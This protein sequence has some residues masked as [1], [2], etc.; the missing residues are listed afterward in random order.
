MQQYFGKITID[1][2]PEMPAG[3]EVRPLAKTMFV[4]YPDCQ[5]LIIWLPQYG[6]NYGAMRLIDTGSKQVIDERP[7]TDRL[8]GSIQLLWDTLD[9][10][11]GEYRVE[12]DHPEGW[13]H[14]IE[15]RKY[16][17]RA[18]LP[19]EPPAEPEPPKES[20][21]IVYRDGFGNIIPNTDLELRE[22]AMQDITNKFARRIE[23]TG[24][25]RAGE[26]I[27]VDNKRRIAFWHEMGG[28]NCMFYIDIPP[29]AQWE[30]RTGTPLEERAEI[31]EFVASTVRSQQASNCRY[32]IG[33]REIGFYYM[34][35]RE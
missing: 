15:L 18:V 29:A 19:A 2:T 25:F 22:K 16:H 33:E 32:E 9:I 7:V 8:S 14:C 10:P 1:E 3:V 13:K 4:H 12:I 11:P 35:S 27:Y 24:T 20:G 31:L 6:R 28:G 30:E 21:P 17:E 23:Y 5:Q 34:Y 26:V